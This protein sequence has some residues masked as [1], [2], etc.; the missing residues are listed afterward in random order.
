MDVSD[1]ILTTVMLATT[2][3]TVT[4]TETAFAT[5][6]GPDV[7][8]PSGLELVEPVVLPVAA[9][10]MTS[11]L[12][13]TDTLLWAKTDHALFLLM[14]TMVDFTVMFTTVH[15]TVN[16]ETMDASDQD[17]TNVT[18]VAQ[19]LDGLLVYVHVLRTGKATAA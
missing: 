14:Y 4:N 13:V 15:V 9:H 8:V 1:Q 11:A 17:Q 16:V 19:T 3:H 18:H 6:D 5:K 2:T 10:V 12:T 7:I